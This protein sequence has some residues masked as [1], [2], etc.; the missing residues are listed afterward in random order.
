VHEP[1]LRRAFEEGRAEVG[2]L[3]LPFETFAQRVVE[4]GRRRLRVYRLPETPDRIAEYLSKAACADLFLASACEEGMAGAWVLFTDRFVPRLFGIARRC[5]ASR[6]EAEEIARS[7][8]GDVASPPP[9]AGARTRIGT[10]DGTGSLFAW[11]AVQVAR[12]V[13]ALRRARHPIPL[14][15][16]PESPAEELP[17]PSPERADPAVIALDEETAELVS[18]AVRSAWTELE[19]RESR[20]LV[21]RFRDGL[22]L[23]E[24][25]P[26]LG[27]SVSRASRILAGAAKKIRSSLDRRLPEESVDRPAEGERRWSS[28]REVLAKYLQ[29]LPPSDNPLPETPP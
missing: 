29:N 21:L 17:D 20:A 9:N 10:Y 5:G 26:R 12:Q 28:L 13:A 15:E 3:P 25:A 16:G 4:L 8:P 2:P 7:V 19:A 22:P 24:I 27:V 18:E 23:K 1:A 11:L 14:G 6:S